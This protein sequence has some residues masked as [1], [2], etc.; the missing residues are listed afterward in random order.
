MRL[1]LQTCRINQRCLPIISMQQGQ[2]SQTDR[3]L[4]FVSQFFWTWQGRGR[5]AK[6]LLSSLITMQN[7]VAVC[8]GRM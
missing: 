2:L 7:L 3:T 8:H 1:R 5:P 4:A 6:F